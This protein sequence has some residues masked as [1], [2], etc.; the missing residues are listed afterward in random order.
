MENE[1]TIC[2]FQF[3]SVLRIMLAF[4]FYFL[5]IV[6]SRLETLLLLSFYPLILKVNFPVL[7]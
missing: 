1:N 3:K 4:I 2:I 6:I 5:F 7:V